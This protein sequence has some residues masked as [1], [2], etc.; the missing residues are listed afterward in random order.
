MGILLQFGDLYGYLIGVL[1]IRESYYFGTLY[2]GSLI[3]VNVH[4]APIRAVE[5][6]FLKSTNSI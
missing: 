5:P 4:V 6:N 2:Y 3:Y 1:M